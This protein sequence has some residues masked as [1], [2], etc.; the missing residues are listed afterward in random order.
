MINFCVDCAYLSVNR[1]NGIGEK[2]NFPSQHREYC[3]VRHPFDTTCLPAACLFKCAG[4]SDF[5]DRQTYVMLDVD[6][7]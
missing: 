6:G 5:R 2:S 4:Y 7:Q 1:V 3:I